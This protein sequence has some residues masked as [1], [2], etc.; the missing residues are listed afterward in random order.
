[1]LCSCRFQFQYLTFPKTR[2]P[3]TPVYLYVKRLVYHTVRL[4]DSDGVT[5]KKMATTTLANNPRYR[6][7]KK[8]IAEG[9]L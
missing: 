3:P 1:M 6:F 9:D 7:K 8:N 2:W 5:N 4:T